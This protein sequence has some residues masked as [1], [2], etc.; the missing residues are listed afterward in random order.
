PPDRPPAP[1]RLDGTARSPPGPPSQRPIWE[2][3]SVAILAIA[4]TFPRQPADKTVRYDAW[5]VAAHWEQTLEEKIQGFAG[6]VLQRSPTL[7][8]A[9]FGLPRALEQMPQRAVQAGLAIRHLVQPPELPHGEEAGH[10][11]LL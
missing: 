3:K 2:Q 4:L 11:G 8:V 10:T 6:V 9:A 5:T 1:A 7:L